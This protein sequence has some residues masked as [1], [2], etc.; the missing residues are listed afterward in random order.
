MFSAAFSLFDKL[1]KKYFLKVT[2]KFQHK[3][4]FIFFALKEPS[5]VVIRPG[6]FPG[7]ANW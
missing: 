2:R 1:A 5:E 7:W 3:R 6:Q 4:P